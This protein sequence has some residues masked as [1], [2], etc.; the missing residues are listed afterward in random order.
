MLDDMHTY[1]SVLPTDLSLELCEADEQDYVIFSLIPRLSHRVVGCVRSTGNVG[2]DIA[3]RLEL[4][5]LAL[6]TFHGVQREGKH[7]TWLIVLPLG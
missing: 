7:S 1:G 5:C 6:S 2:L 3:Q 4:V